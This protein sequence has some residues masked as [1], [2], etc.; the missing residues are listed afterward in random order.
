MSNINKLDPAILRLCVE[1]IHR[2]I[3]EKDSLTLSKKKAMKKLN[4]DDVHEREIT[5]D[6]EY[7]A[8]KKKFFTRQNKRID[9]LNLQ[10]N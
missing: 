7:Q 1:L 3:I 8:I 2:F 4:I 6:P 9:D 5:S 10:L